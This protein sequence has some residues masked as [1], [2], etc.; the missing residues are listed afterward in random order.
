MEMCFSKWR[1]FE[2]ATADSYGHIKVLIMF[3]RTGLIKVYLVAPVSWAVCLSF[4]T[5]QVG[6]S[7]KKWN[8]VQEG[9]PIRCKVEVEQLR[10]YVSHFWI[11]PM[12]WSGFYQ[13]SG[14]LWRVYFHHK[15]A[16]E[17]YNDLCG[18]TFW[19]RTQS[20]P[21]ITKLFKFLRRKCV[22]KYRILF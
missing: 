22:P 20:Q 8:W 17:R 16:T 10:A 13:C 4:S 7:S 12:I 18:R 11:S 14:I 6:S 3:S 5:I 1:A 21:S 15:W 9:S 2:T 19:R